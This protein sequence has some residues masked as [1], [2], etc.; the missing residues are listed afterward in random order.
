MKRLLVFAA[1][2]LLAFGLLGSTGCSEKM[3]R[4]ADVSAG[5]YYNEE[6]F[7]SLGDDQREQY[8]A[9]LADEL[10]GLSEATAKAES[11]AAGVDLDQL[12]AEL[13]HLQG[14][15]NSQAGHVKQVRDEIEYFEGLPKDYTVVKGDCLWNISGFESIYADPVQWPRIYRAN[16][17]Q[18]KDPDLIYPDQVFAI[19][20]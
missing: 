13:R 8:C 6:E 20:R 15:Y 4:Q 11:D 16:K 10:E 17:D 9:D 19:P 3:V 14:E 7:N 1:I 12:R 18:I 5:D 2:A